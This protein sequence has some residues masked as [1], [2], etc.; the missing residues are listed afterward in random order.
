[1][2]VQVARVDRF[3]KQVD[4][5]VAQ[6]QT[7]TS[8]KLARHAPP[9]RNRG[10]R[11]P[12][13]FDRATAPSRGRAG[14][15][16]RPSPARPPAVARTLRSSHAGRPMLPRTRQ[17][18]TLRRRGR[19]GEQSQSRDRKFAPDGRLEAR[20]QARDAQPS[21]PPKSGQPQRDGAQLPVRPGRSGSWRGRGSRARR[22]DRRGP[23]AGK[24]P[25]SG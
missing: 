10:D 12:R 7:A 11:F 20:Q 2:D 3:K 16:R 1:L 21:H 25:G 22:P 24:H 19:P 17:S 18:E 6:G 4:F 9:P 23:P 13:P 15:P 5:R 8:S 14:S